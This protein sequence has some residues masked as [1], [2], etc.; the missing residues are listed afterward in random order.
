MLVLLKLI[1]WTQTI[2]L[3]IRMGKMLVLL[4]SFLFSRVGGL[5]PFLHNRSLDTNMHASF[6][7]YIAEYP[8]SKDYLWRTFPIQTSPLPPYWSKYILVSI[9]GKLAFHGKSMAYSTYCWSKR[10]NG[11]AIDSCQDQGIKLNYSLTR[12]SPGMSF[13][14]AHLSFILL[15][16]LLSMRNSRQNTLARRRTSSSPGNLSWATR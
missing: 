8:T 13:A 14:I 16:P 10:W 11:V 9:R 15:E 12:T 4:T 3:L 5:D 1:R 7:C 6:T 2:S